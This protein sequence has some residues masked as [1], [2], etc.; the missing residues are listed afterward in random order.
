MKITEPTTPPFW[1][2]LARLIHGKNVWRTIHQIE[3]GPSTLLFFIDTRLPLNF[4]KGVPVWF[5]SNKLGIESN[6][7]MI[8]ANLMV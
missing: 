4:W 2:V 8:S 3:I 6:S 7:S 1:Q 5:Y